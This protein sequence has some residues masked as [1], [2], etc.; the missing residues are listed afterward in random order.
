LSADVVT[1]FEARRLQPSVPSLGFHKARQKVIR[2]EMTIDESCS[3]SGTRFGRVS[4]GKTCA[5]RHGE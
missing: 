5:A 1:L 4:G 2:A 3:C